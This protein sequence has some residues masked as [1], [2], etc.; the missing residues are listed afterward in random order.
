MVFISDAGENK[1][2]LN[3]AVAKNVIILDMSIL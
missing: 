3:L 2:F 1:L